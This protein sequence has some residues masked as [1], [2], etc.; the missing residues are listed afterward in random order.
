MRPHASQQSLVPSFQGYSAA[1]IRIPSLFIVLTHV[2]APVRTLSCCQR[3]SGVPLCLHFCKIVAL[4]IYLF[5]ICLLPLTLLDCYRGL[6]SP[7]PYSQSLGHRNGPD[8]GKKGEKWLLDLT[9]P[10]RGQQNLWPECVF[11]VW[12]SNHI[13]KTTSKCICQVQVFSKN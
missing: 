4:N 7:Q 8:E 11:V 10:C 12:V 6:A 9:G 5:I 3:R 1:L 13:C 2:P